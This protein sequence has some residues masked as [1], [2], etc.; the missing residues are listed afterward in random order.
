MDTSYDLSFQNIRYQPKSFVPFRKKPPKDILKSVCGEFRGNELSAI[1]GLSGSGKTSLLD[2]LS[3]FRCDN[4]S[5]TFML[6][7]NSV[8]ISSIK[9]VSSYVM[10]EQTLHVLLTIN[11]IM[12]LSINLRDKWNLNDTEKQQKIKNILEK[13]SIE[14]RCHTYIRDLSGGERKRVQVAV[15]LVTDPT[16]LFLDE[17]TTGLDSV[18][19]TQCIHMLQKLSKD[20]KTIIC[21][22]H[23]PST[24]MLRMFNHVYALADGQC[25]YQGSCNNLIAFFRELDLSCPETYNPADFLIE[26]ANNDYGLHNHRLVEKIKNGKNSNY[27][28]AETVR[29]FN[30]NTTVSS[31]IIMQSS[32]EPTKYSS[33]YLRQV[34]YL[35]HRLFLITSRDSSHFYIR[36]LIHVLLGFTFGCIYKDVGNNGS[37]MLDNYRFLVISVVFLLYTSYHSLFIAFPIEYPIIKREHFNGWYSTRAYYTSFVL[38]DFPIVLLCCFSY[39]SITYWMTDQPREL[40]RFLIFLF[41]ALFMSIAAQSLGTMITALMDVKMSTILGTFFLTPFFLFSAIMITTKDAHPFF[42]IFFKGNFLDCSLKAILNS[43]LGFNRKKL[44]CDEIYCHFENPKKVLRDFGA[45]INMTYA[46]S[47][48]MLYVLFCQVASFILFRYRLK[49]RVS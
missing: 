19:S 4:V 17:C 46:F 45:E 32:S 38:F 34:Y 26:L 29:T 42:H 21:T 2:C 18:A 43:V 33:S 35:M 39:I 31:E 14:S 12:N 11:E 30:N 23:Q 13:L 6:N 8:P 40:H 36:F 27:R 22:I 5:G 28:H 9:R 41:F 25:I 3:G 15:E 47:I 44:E 1:V 16:I 7:G 49:N 24:T 20:G 48:L 10:Q 37:A